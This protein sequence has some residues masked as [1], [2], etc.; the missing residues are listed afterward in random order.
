MVAL[1]LMFALVGYPAFTNW[2]DKARITAV[3]RSAASRMQVA[4]QEA[5]KMNAAVVAQPD[6][7]TDEIVFFVNVDG[8]AGFAFN[9]DP[10]VPFKTA[11]YE[12]GRLQLPVDDYD[13]TFWAPRDARPEGGNAIDGLS[14]TSAPLNAVI[15]EPPGSVRD[16]GAIRIADGRSNFFELRV[17]PQATGKVQVLKYHP[18]PPWGDSAGFFPRGRHPDTGDPMWEWY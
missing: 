5:I 10:D 6:F 13:I 4:R 16:V 8:D 17:A 9:P 14:P 1:L 12:L 11:D 18:N 15:F 3:V 2:T 7:D